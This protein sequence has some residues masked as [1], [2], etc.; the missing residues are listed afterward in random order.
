[1]QKQNNRQCGQGLGGLGCKA[2]FA[3]HPSAYYE[4]SSARDKPSTYNNLVGAGNRDIVR[5]RKDTRGQN[6]EAKK[7]RFDT[8]SNRPQ[9]TCQQRG[10]KSK[11]RN[12]RK[13]R[14]D[15][16]DE[17]SD[18][19]VT[20]TEDDEET[21]ETT[22]EET[23]DEDDDEMYSEDEE[24]TDIDSGEE[25]ETDEEEEDNE[26]DEDNNAKDD[27][28]VD[29]RNDEDS[30]S[31]R[32]MEHNSQKR[33]RLREKQKRTLAN[34]G[35]GCGRIVQPATCRKEEEE[36][37]D[38]ETALVGGRR[39]RP[40]YRRPRRKAYRRRP[41]RKAYRRRPR[42]RYS[43]RRRYTTRRSGW[44]RGRSTDEN[45]RFNDLRCVTI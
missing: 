15:E 43:T 20:M 2:L 25:L 38:N 33:I 39:R 4:V 22:E 3:L 16:H 37:E 24:V 40:R 45:P 12:Q 26:D 8:S 19:E 13:K 11:P 44:G 30:R 32:K 7:C 9:R 35:R 17:T 14:K 10:E 29:D 21:E 1:M 34:S 41:R 6:T 23:E 42:R 31:I 5:K 27:V 28:D 18:D 36:E